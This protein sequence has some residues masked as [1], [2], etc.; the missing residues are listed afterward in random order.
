MTQRSVWL[1]R[2]HLNRSVA[3]SLNEFL[4]DIPQQR[5]EGADVNHLQDNGYGPLHFAF[6]LLNSYMVELL[7]ELEAD[8][9]LKTS[10][11]ISGYDMAEKWELDLDTLKE[12][13]LGKMDDGCTMAREAARY[14]DLY[15]ISQ[16]AEANLDF[17]RVCPGG[18][19][20]L[21]LIHADDNKKVIDLLIASGADVNAQDYRGNT[22]L[23]AAAKEGS[24]TNVKAL[25][26]H[27]ADKSL[28]NDDGET[29]YDKIR[30]I[31]E[32]ELKVLLAP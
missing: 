9:A 27:G 21:A 2:A 30:A 1:L 12:V 7:I 32:V 15:R 16:L 14:G 22:P 13:D 20:Q 26:S 5:D 19:Q 8:P 25:L 23:I 10:K 17:N 6:R 24:L 3:S 11:G 4:P 28:E 18:G 29:A 31:D